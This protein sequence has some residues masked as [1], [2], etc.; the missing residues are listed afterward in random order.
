MSMPGVNTVELDPA[1]VDILDAAL[2]IAYTH[3]INTGIL[4]NQTIRYARDALVRTMV[5]SI[6]A[7]ERDAWRVARRGIFAMCEQVALA[8]VSAPAAS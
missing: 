8:G 3:L 1:G 4:K 5:H 6:V 2:R 7:G